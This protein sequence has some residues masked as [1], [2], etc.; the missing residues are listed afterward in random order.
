M[1]KIACPKCN[2]LSLRYLYHDNSHAESRCKG[3]N[4]IGLSGTENYFY[5][6]NNC[7]GYIESN[8]VH[9]LKWT[10]ENPLGE[11]LA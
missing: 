1:L 6:C 7:K 5:Y 4:M 8:I 3:K 9:I 2:S 10:K 11:T